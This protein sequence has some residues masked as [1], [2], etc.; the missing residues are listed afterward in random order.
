MP[1]RLGEA[2][3]KDL[4]PSAHF[5]TGRMPFGLPSIIEKRQTK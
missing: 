1:I 5:E 4:A 3:V 2:A